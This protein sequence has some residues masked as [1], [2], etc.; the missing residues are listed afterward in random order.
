MDSHAQLKIMSANVHRINSK[1][2]GRELLG[3]IR[4]L[5]PTVVYLQEIGIS[6]ALEVFKPFYHVYVNLDEECMGPERIGIA[7]IVKRGI[8]ILEVILGSEG[9]TIGVKIKEIQFWN[10]YPRSGTGEKKWRENYFREE[11][12]NM[13]T[14]WRGHTKYTSQGGDFNCTHRLKDSENNQAQHLQPA[15]Q[16][17]MKV[18][19]LQ[20]DY[21]RLNG[22]DV[23]YSRI[24]NRS[25]TRIDIIMSDMQDC[26]HFEYWESGLPSYDHKF[27]ISEY[28]ILMD[29]AKENIPRERRFFKWAFPKELE[30]DEDFLTE[31]EDVCR[32]IN[33]EIEEEED[34]SEITEKWNYLK[35]SIIRIAKE[36]TKELR[37]EE[38]GRLEVLRAFMQASLS[39][40]ERGLDDFENFK[41]IRM[42]IRILWNKKTERI[43]EKNKSVEIEDHVYDLHKLEKQKKY[44]NG[45]NIRKLNIEGTKFEGTL[46]ILDGLERKIKTEVEDFDVD[47][48]EEITEEEMFFLKEMEILR[49]TEAEK[50][51][52]IGAV[53]EEECE[54]IF[55]NQVNLDS[56]PGPDG[57]T[58]RLFYLLFRKVTFFKGIFVK[59]INWTRNESSLG[60]LEN[61][62]VMK[63]IN[64]KRFSEEYDGK[65]KLTVIN[66]DIN[67][68]GKIWT[69][70][71]RQ[72]VL[73]KVLPKTQYNCQEDINVVDENREIRDVVRHLRG[74]DDHGKEKD[75]SL[76]AIDFRDAFRSVYLRWFKLVLDYLEVP[77][78]FRKWFWSM[79]EGLAIIIVVNGAKSG[80][81]HIRRGFMEGHPPSMPGFVAAIIPLLIV[82][83][84]NME[85]IKLKNGMTKKIFSFADD[86]KL[87]LKDP[88]EIHHIFSIIC[89]FQKV[90]GLSMH[91]DPKRG[92]CQALTFGVHRNYT[93]WP[94]WLTV[95]EIVNILGILYSNIK[96]KTL[97]QVNSDHVKNKVLG[98]L[99]AASGIRG[100]VL[101]KTQY[102]NTYLLSKVWYVAQSIRLKEAMLKELDQKVTKFIY[103]GQNERPVRALFYRPK[104]V[105]GLQLICVSTKA[106]SFMVKSM[107]REREDMDAG[108]IEGT[109]YGDE[110]DLN[111][112]LSSDINRDNIREIYALLLQDK[113]GTMDNLIKSRSETRN[114]RINWREAWTNWSKLGGVSAEVKYFAWSLIQDMLFVPSRNHRGDK[115]KDCK[116]LVYNMSLN[117]MEI[118]G[119]FGDLQ[120]TL[121]KCGTIRSKFDV[122]TA[123]LEN[124]LGKVV[125]VDEL[126]FLTLR[127]FD[128]KKQK[129]SIWLSVT[130]LHFMFL[131]RDAE[132][133]DLLRRLKK[134]LFWHTA[135]ERWFCGRSQM[136]EMLKIIEEK[137][138]L[139]LD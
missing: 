77:V 58:Y 11:L 97:E 105:G 126:L 111:R 47:L 68:I 91:L 101:Q 132:E 8:N 30:D 63:V 59:M 2:R 86:M 69:N 84:K 24:T 43:L 75:G 38:K 14:N 123:L 49:M 16:K 131:D 102:A 96:N 88:R 138:L 51:K 115:N 100:T 62:G 104:E 23:C 128:K 114:P 56:S 28:N 71:F 99:F 57:C 7:T 117:E 98:K 31:A 103:A 21:V 26:V 92:K 133:M 89:K 4:N 22:E 32:I 135:L 87:I 139:S 66:K 134:E 81:I 34:D 53:S 46:Q 45:S 94:A 35:E 130:A 12:P 1:T 120:H 52:I 113:I 27:A 33:A 93:A 106:R 108:D 15:L 70:R 29:V 121:T 119:D 136:M 65:R 122:L 25:K 107:A 118:C 72:N 44:E 79:Y 39:K 64:K 20:D 116:S 18:F 13:M 73:T 76:I 78:Q 83:E 90:S 67:F 95:K 110:K 37:E 127:H 3:M 54:E 109:I 19:G 36:R 125:T 60:Y 6:M 80:K 48:E 112:I 17:H 9:R 41:K 82:L 61:L 40:I 50:Q 124:F 137:M 74:D 5:D 129:L 85:G 42:E 10:I 55:K